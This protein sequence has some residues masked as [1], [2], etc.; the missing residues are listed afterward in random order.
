[1]ARRRKVR[2]DVL[3]A[4]LVLA[5]IGLLTGWFGQES[6]MPLLQE[7]AEKLGYK[8]P[9]H[10]FG[11]IDKT[12]FALTD[13]EVNGKLADMPAAAKSEPLRFLMLNTHNYFVPEDTQRARYKIVP[14]RIDSRDAVAD[15]IASARPE[16]VGLI[17]IGG[18]FALADLQSRLRK[19]GAEYP[20]AEILLRAGEDRALAILSKHRIVQNHSRP[21]C[22]LLGNKRRKMLR[23]ILDVTVQVDGKRFFRIVG[24]HL[25]SR[26]SDDPAAAESLRRAES[27]TLALYLQE[28]MRKMPKM[29]F[30]VF[31]DWNDGPAD[32]SLKVLT[33]GLSADAALTRVG[34]EDS[35]GESWTICYHAAQEYCVF[36]QVYVNSVMRSRRGRSCESGIVDV[37]AASTAS[38]HR[39][40]WCELR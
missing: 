33:Q 30:V 19:L 28:E 25:K 32:S 39:A 23:G 1:M 37:E 7:F 15:V 16:I 31:G 13:A 4:T 3:L 12:A 8:S 38:D 22:S 17:E 11:E 20:Y 27:R 35:R 10:D 21:N 36:D 5:C 6:P 2:L 34:A 9:A 29:P 18:P 40:V 14:K 26:V 24:A